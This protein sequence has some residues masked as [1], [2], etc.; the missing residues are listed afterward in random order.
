[1]YCNYLE[2]NVEKKEVKRKVA[3]MQKELQ[4]AVKK[5]EKSSMAKARRKGKKAAEEAAQK[6]TETK[7]L[8][9]AAE[10]KELKKRLAVYE[11]GGD[12]RANPT[13]DTMVV[14]EKKKRHKQRS[15][16]WRR[17]SN[18]LRKAGIGIHGDA[19][20]YMADLLSQVTSTHKK[21][22]AILALPVVQARWEFVSVASVLLFVLYINCLNEAPHTRTCT[23]THGGLG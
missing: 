10:V 18:A 7:E 19:A 13:R 2:R 21:V 5:K 3:E 12:V 22:D 17:R 6:A 15:S 16:T 8:K 1:M 14:T 20:G 11:P 9:L 23:H 4:K